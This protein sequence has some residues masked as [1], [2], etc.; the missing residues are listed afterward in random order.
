ML[1]L[2]GATVETVDNGTNGVLFAP[3]PI[4]DPWT[5]LPNDHGEYIDGILVRSMNF[6]AGEGSPHSPDQQQLL[7]LVWMLAIAF[8]SVQPT[9]PLAL[10]LGPAGSGKSSMFRRIG[11]MFYGPQLM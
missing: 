11:R 10:A 1:K 9:K 3:T 2:D 7:L 5:W 8:E 6:A 4:S